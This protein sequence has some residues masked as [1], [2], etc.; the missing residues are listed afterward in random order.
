MIGRVDQEVEDVWMNVTKTATRRDETRRSRVGLLCALAI[1]LSA[2]AAFAQKPAQAQKPAAKVA[3][4][5]DLAEKAKQAVAQKDALK[6]G[7]SRIDQLLKNVDPEL[8]KRLM[9][10]DVTVEMVG[11][12]LIL[13]GPE[14]AV[15]VLELLIR[16]L[17]AERQPKVIEIVTIT[18]RD[19]NEVARTVQEAIREATKAAN[20]LPE[21][22]V[23][24]TALSA[25]VILVAAIPTEIDWV[26]EVI[27]QVDAVPDP[28]GKIDLMTFEIKYRRASDVAEELDEIIKSIRDAIG[29]GKEG[30]KLQIRAVDANNTIFVTARESERETIENLIKQI[31]VEPVSGFGEVKLTLFPLLHSNADELK[32]VI[33]DL[34]KSDGGSG[35]SSS[36]EEVIQRLRISKLDPSGELVELPPIDLQKA[37]RILSDKGTNS[38]IIATADENVEPLRELIR[39]LD[40]VPLAEDVHV[41]LFPLRFAAV[42]TLSDTLTQMFSDAKELPLD[43]DGAGQDGVPAGATG[44]A[45][46][47]NV[48]FASDTR[49]NTLIASGRP[50][51]LTLIERLV[52]DL[53]QPSRSLKFPLKFVR[54]QHTDATQLGKIITTLFDQRFEAAQSTGATGAALERERVFLSTDIRSNS[55]IVSASEENFIEI[56][57]VAKQLDTKPAKLFDLIRIIPC[58]RL[59]AKNAKEKIDELWKRKATLRSEAE[60][61]EDLP[62]VVTDERSNSLIVASNMEDFD[63]IARLIEVLE[64]QPLID[65]MQLFELRYADSKVMADMLAELF[66]GIAGQSET[67]EAPTII[68]DPRSNA[69]VVA[70]P[71]DTMERVKD[72]LRRLD[73]EAGPMSAVFKVYALSNVS[74]VQISQRM[75]ELFDSRDE[76]D[77]TTRT[78]VVILPEESSN[79]LIVSASRDDHIVLVGLLELLDKPSTLA[80]YFKIFPLRLAKVTSV[81]E[82]LDALFQS[83]GEGSSGRADAIAVEAD[84]RTNSIIVWASPTQMVN[85]GEVIS[86]LDTS[87][88][89]VEMMVKVIQLKQALAEDFATLLEETISGDGG[90]NEQAVIVSFIETLPD[91]RKIPRK[92]L[93]QDIKIQPDPRTNSL[94]VMAPADSMAMLE[95]MIM[96]FDRIRP[97]TSEIRLF[98]LVNSDADTMVQQLTDLFQA[99]S[100]TGEDGA[101]AA[102]LTFGGTSDEDLATIGQELRFASDPRTNT[103]IAAGAEIYLNMVEDLI[104]YLDSQEAESRVTEVYQ[105]KFRDGN[106][107]QAAVEDFISQELDVLGEVTDE[108]SRQLRMDRQVSIAAIG[109]EESGSSSLIIGTSRRSYQETMDMVRSLDRPEPQVMISVLI[110]EVALNKNIDLGVEIAGQD[111]NFSKNAIVGPNGIISGSNFDAIVGTALNASGPLGFSFTVTGE[112]FSFLFRAL[113][114]ENRL[115]VLS[116]PILM[117]RN[118]EE[119]NITVADQIPIISSSQVTTNGNIVA[120]PG[121]EDAGVI[122]T[123]TPQISPD[124]YVTIALA[125]EISNIGENIDLG[126]GVSQPIISTR[127]VTTNVTVRDGE[128][129]VIGGLIQARDASSTTKVPFLGD[130]PYIGALFRSTSSST[131]KTELLIVMTVD[132]LRTDEDIYRM[133]VDQRDKYALPD[134]ILHDPLMEGLRIVPDQDGM[135]P[136]PD[137]GPHDLGPSKRERRPTYGPK[138]V[139]ANATHTKKTGVYGPRIAQR[140]SSEEVGAHVSGGG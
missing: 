31:D 95:A 42:E 41:K 65:D 68:P 93:R 131:N 44:R 62:I 90:D 136:R 123:A 55:L 33:E 71:R 82:Q 26:I 94:M 34:L 27:H 125:Q 14:E 8:L 124:G 23:T 67:F 114:Q 138:V 24:L 52:I 18:E 15:A 6:A 19:A 21:D 99:D 43:P 59:S 75:Q 46:V 40:G 73:V 50:E 105:A 132:I 103:I 11:D 122:L 9:G 137:H 101:T 39:L 53:D 28:L 70:A 80:R 36:V 87:S 134:H 25:N 127:E 130:L 92:L 32:S 60:M 77:D 116:R 98:P 115:D 12:Q 74:A 13:Q 117:V 102:Q 78:P 81:A 119:G 112:D 51:Q 20:K 64:A 120:Q 37:I 54:L 56:S 108:E 2:T 38:L 3:K 140:S 45:L 1:S 85:I 72:V 100:V 4:K 129:V 106:Q 111:L 113:Q 89:A 16:G 7:E 96:D 84:D 104:R 97:I 35:S 139:P 91:G 63:E 121:R 29:V 5:N 110:A 79:N 30:G 17:D 48:G 128:T 126:N 58:S 22:E 57:V 10:A 66:D 133:S 109:D 135:G 107:L 83:T 69:L 76:G 118:G 86:Q 88:P 49:T 47:Y 61:L